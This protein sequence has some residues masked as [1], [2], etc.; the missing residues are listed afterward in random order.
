MKI[1]TKIFVKT[2]L[3]ELF[4]NNNNKIKYSEFFSVSK[5]LKYEICDD[6]T[7]NDAIYQMIKKLTK[8]NI[9]SETKLKKMFNQHGIYNEKKQKHNKV[10]NDE[11]GDDFETIKDFFIDFL[12][13]DDY[14]S[15]MASDSDIFSVNINEKCNAA[16]IHAIQKA[17]A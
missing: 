9:N 14:A 6:V 2:L 8:L 5:L 17:M 10:M 16:I 4:D 1:D 11:I 12:V 7:L 13:F 15:N 3:K